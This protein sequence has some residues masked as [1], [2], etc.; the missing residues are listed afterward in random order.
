[1]ISS[2]NQL[3]GFY[4]ITTTVQNELIL[5]AKI[6]KGYSFFI[7]EPEH[8][9]VFL[10]TVTDD[11]MRGFICHVPSTLSQLHLHPGTII[12]YIC[13]SCGSFSSMTT[14]K[15][16]LPASFSSFSVSGFSVMYN[17]ADIV[18]R[19]FV[20]R[21]C[22]KSRSPHTNSFKFTKKSHTPVSKLE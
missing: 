6:S 18:E 10:I 12:I 17:L 19:C 11:R 13:L 14:L 5:I 1:M 21:G 9:L 4:I 20:H 7:Y 8:T 15:S 16:L 22:G 3:T 2:A